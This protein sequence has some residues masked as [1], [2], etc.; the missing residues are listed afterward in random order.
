RVRPSRSAPRQLL[1][2]PTRRSSDLK[3]IPLSDMPNNLHRRKA[4]QRHRQHLY[5]HIQMQTKQETY[6]REKINSRHDITFKPTHI[7]RFKELGSG[8]KR[9]VCKTI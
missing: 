7:R 2:F 4:H 1:S 6:T 8:S 9:E 5:K 3:A